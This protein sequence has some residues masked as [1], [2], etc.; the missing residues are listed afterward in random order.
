MDRLGRRVHSIQN[1]VERVDTARPGRVEEP[2]LDIEPR[3]DISVLNLLGGN[4]AVDDQLNASDPGRFIRSQIE[5]T[6]GNVT[7]LAQAA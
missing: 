5:G 4:S 3:P 6:V 7:G 2:G 1:G